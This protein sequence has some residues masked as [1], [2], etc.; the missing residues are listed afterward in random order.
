MNDVRRLALTF[1]RI[2]REAAWAPVAVL[3]LNFFVVRLYE[4]FFWL[5]HLLGGAA[6]GFFFHQAIR[7][8]GDLL[9][10]LRA[11]AQYVFAFGLACTVGLFWEIAEFA[12]DR[13]LLTQLQED[14]TETMSDLILDV[15][16]AAVALAVIACLGFVAR[17]RR[18]D[19]SGQERMH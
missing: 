14:L 8:A 12:I 4:D 13:I 16:G 1:V 17:S 10:S 6:L 19:R 7:I 18:P 3:S 11:F 15:T 9:G 2:L 5:L